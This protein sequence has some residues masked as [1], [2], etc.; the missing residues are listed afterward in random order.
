MLT[1]RKKITKKSWLCQTGRICSGKFHQPDTRFWSKEKIKKNREKKTHQKGKDRFTC[2]PSGHS[3]PTHS[4]LSL[5]L[6]PSSRLHQKKK[7]EKKKSPAAQ[8]VAESNQKDTYKKH[9]NSLRLGVYTSSG[10]TLRPTDRAAFPPSL[11]LLSP[12]TVMSLYMQL[13]GA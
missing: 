12:V 4:S 1:K 11:S 2:L 3:R 5:S 6:S 13:V 7:A 9:H 10:S 8:I